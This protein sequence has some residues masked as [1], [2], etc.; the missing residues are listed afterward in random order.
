MRTSAQDT[1]KYREL[2]EPMASYDSALKPSLESGARPT[3][4]TPWRIGRD[5]GALSGDCP[6]RMRSRVASGW[7]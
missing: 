6:P 1:A 5:Y 7:A 4:P 3:T 2:G